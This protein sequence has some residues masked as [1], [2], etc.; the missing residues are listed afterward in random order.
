VGEVVDAGDPLATRLV[1]PALEAIGYVDDRIE[2][3]YSSVRRSQA[4]LAYVDL[5]AS[6]VPAAAE[7]VRE[8]ME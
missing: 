7:F 1:R 5:Y 4:E 8:R 6:A 2:E 3:G